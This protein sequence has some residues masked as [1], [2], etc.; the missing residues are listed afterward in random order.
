MTQALSP[1]QLEDEAA[2]LLGQLLFAFGRLEASL[3]FFLTWGRDDWPGALDQCHEQCTFAGKLDLVLQWA[4]QRY[5]DDVDAYNKCA[6]W[7][8]AADSVREVRNRLAHGR[9]GFAYGA[10]VVANVSGLPGSPSQDE[11][12]YSLNQLENEVLEVRRVQAEF[13]ELW[14]PLRP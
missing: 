3:G 11:R 4:G 9:W 10:Q 8:M 1:T 6:A 7:Y 14:R 2:R 5:A 13:E 12:R